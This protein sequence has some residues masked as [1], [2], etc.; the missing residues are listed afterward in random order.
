MTPQ[1]KNIKNSQKFAEIKSVGPAD[2][3]TWTS[4]VRPDY[5]IRR[6]LV[7]CLSVDLRIG[8]VLVSEALSRAIA[9][10]IACIFMYET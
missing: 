3:K 4:L 6:V 1:L 8:K 9:C 10:T 5:V 7:T 2:L